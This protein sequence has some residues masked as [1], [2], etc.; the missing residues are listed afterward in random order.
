MYSRHSGQINRQNC[1]FV[2]A[3]ARRTPR[4]GG[5]LQ[6]LRAIGVPRQ[7]RLPFSAPRA[8]RDGPDASFDARADNSV[9]FG[10]VRFGCARPWRAASTSCRR[11]YLRRGTAR[12]AVRRVESALHRFPASGQFDDVGRAELDD[13]NRAGC[14]LSAGT[15]M[16]RVVVCLAPAFA[17]E[18]FL[19]FLNTLTIAVAEVT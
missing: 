11:I 15:I 19:G 1:G 12:V 10:E 13:V 18:R 8:G 7:R 2:R 16:K 9:C 14:A 17:V 5:W 6:V 3:P 4:G